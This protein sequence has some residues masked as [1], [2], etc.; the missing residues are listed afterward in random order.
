MHDLK[1]SHRVE[2]RDLLWECRRIDFV[3]KMSC[4]GLGD[5]PLYKVWYSMIYRCYHPNSSSFPRYGAKGISVCERWAS[6][7]N[8]INDMRDSNGY[9][10]DRINPKGDYDPTNCRWASR[11]TQAVNV[12]CG[13]KERRSKCLSY[14]MKK[15]KMP[16]RNIVNL[17]HFRSI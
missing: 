14:M 13:Y 15:K 3:S 16:T 12:S 5:H 10:I 4:D 7:R 6:L 1:L 17:F 8:F 9:T 11:T 2:V